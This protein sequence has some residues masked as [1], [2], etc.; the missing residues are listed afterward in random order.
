MNYEAGLSN[1]A[2]HR[3]LCRA[4]A[5]HRYDFDAQGKLVVGGGTNVK[6]G[7]TH[8]MGATR[9]VA[10]QEATEA[11]DFERA[12]AL[13]SVPDERVLFGQEAFDNLV[14][15]GARE[16]II[17]VVL[18]GE[19]PVTTWYYGPFLSNW[20]PL[21]TAGS[22]WAGSGSGPLATELAVSQFEGTAR[23]AATF[24]DDPVSALIT[25]SETVELALS[26]TVTTGITVYGNTLNSTD[27]VEY[28]S[29]DK[30]LLSAAKRTEPLSGLLYG[31]GI[32]MGYVFGATS[33]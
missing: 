2:L 6:V 31:D 1:K 27:Y 20:I 32:V 22:N 24:A 21:D 11:G 4:V 9:S 7:G 5:N 33:V 16:H 28:N 13:R 19:T 30:V 25:S 15:E 12:W 26:A 17:K 14:P 8:W 23:A 3:D 18:A 29:T 10:V